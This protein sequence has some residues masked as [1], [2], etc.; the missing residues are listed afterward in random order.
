[1]TP[2]KTLTL[3]L[4]IIIVILLL[5]IIG[6]LA[7]WRPWEPQKIDRT[8]TITGTAE[9]QA[10]PDEFVFSPT[11]QHTGTDTTK[12]KADLDTF[13]TKLSTDVQK[14][15]IAGSAITLNS[16][17]YGSSVEPVP[18]DVGSKPSGQQTVTLSVTIKAPTQALAQKVQDYLAA[19]D[20]TGQLTSQPSFSKQ[21]QKDLEKQARDKAVADAKDKAGDTAKNLSVTLG[22][23]VSVKDQ[24]NQ[25]IVYPMSASTSKD[26]AVSS[27][28]VTPG[29]SSVSM[30]V[31]VVFELR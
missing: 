20:A 27:L 9:V 17:S 13:G 14:L 26:S 7:F 5:T 19:T 15:G 29:T 24:P 4:R 28:P 16:S 8:I 18:M 1:M 3:D 22:K 31:E 25:G 12:M 2:K 10:T 21:K 6:M 30:S 11:F 23:V